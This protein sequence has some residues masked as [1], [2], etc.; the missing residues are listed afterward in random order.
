M[1]VVMDAE[2][3]GRA[4][5]RIAHEIVERSRTFDDLAIVGVRT[6]GVPIARRLAQ[7]IAAIS[8]V[9]TLRSDSGR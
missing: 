2:R 9:L 1:P 4:L 7:N 6:R 5:M 3:V 8:T